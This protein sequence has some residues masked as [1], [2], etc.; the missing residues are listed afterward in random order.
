MQATL[1]E[2][3]LSAFSS[4]HVFGAAHSEALEE[5]RG[6]QVL[7][8]RAWGRSEGDDGDVVDKD[9]SK[10]GAG[11]GEMG[12]GRGE[13]GQVDGDEEQVDILMARMRREANER[14]F[15]KVQEGVGD[16]VGRLEIV[17]EAMGKVERE[18]REIWESGSE[19]LDTGSMTS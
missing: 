14:F 18:S 2:V 8:A 9:G 15:K 6:A 3:E 5:L 17:A 19:S 13:D 16:V 4:T 1:A 7:L 12:K 11:G 10:G